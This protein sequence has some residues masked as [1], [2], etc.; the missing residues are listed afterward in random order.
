MHESLSSSCEAI[1][2]ESGRGAAG[3]TG[4]WGRRRAR[5]PRPVVRRLPAAAARFHRL[6]RTRRTKFHGIAASCTVSLDGRRE[7]GLVERPSSSGEQ[8]RR[9]G[10]R[11]DRARGG[12]GKL[13]SDASFHT[14]RGHHGPVR[15]WSLSC[16]RGAGLA[17]CSSTAKA[18][19]LLSS[20]V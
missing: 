7:G 18:L 16:A 8:V 13:G 6:G 1:G 19:G 2:M 5:W 14:G 3:W 17:A 9:L 15:I 11:R 12:L 10:R 20:K 4:G